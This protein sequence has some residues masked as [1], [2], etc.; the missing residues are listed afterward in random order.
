LRLERAMMEMKRAAEI[1]NNIVVNEDLDDCVEEVHRL[2][3]AARHKL[4]ERKEA[5]ET[6]YPGL[7][8]A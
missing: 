8:I 7:E 4:Q 6:L 2:V 5:G 3:Q 1:Y